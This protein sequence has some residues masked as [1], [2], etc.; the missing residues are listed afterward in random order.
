MRPLPVANIHRPKSR[1]F[2]VIAVALA[3]TVFLGFAPSY[4]FRS[5]TPLPGLSNLVQLHA[6]V[7][8]CWILLFMIQTMLVANRRTDIHRLLGAV[9]IAFAIGVVLLGI[10][11]D[12][13]TITSEQQAAWQSQ[14]PGLVVNMARFM[15]RNT[16]NVI[17][18]AIL[19]TAAVALR[20]KPQIHKRLMVL[21][22][23]S[24]ICQ[25]NGSK[26]KE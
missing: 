20:R 3:A 7:F 8:S 11:V 19:F 17:M 24:I 15:V 25:P 18:F 5:F 13:A 12:L 22:T 1:F 4:Y 2:V 6:L 14:D 21:A 10:A 16:G 23:I 26:S 9:G